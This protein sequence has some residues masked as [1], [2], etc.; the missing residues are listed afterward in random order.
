LDV[1]RNL[2]TRFKNNQ[3]LKARVVNS[4]ME[5]KMQSLLQKSVEITV[6]V[7]E[8]RLEDYQK[9][10]E[11]FGVL[12]LSISKPLKFEELGLA[13]IDDGQYQC[14]ACSKTFKGRCAKSNSAVHFKKFH[15]D[16]PVESSVQCPRCPEEMAKSSLN[17][18]MEQKHQL[19]NF[20]QL[21]KRSYLPDASEHSVDKG[22]MPKTTSVRTYKDPPSKMQWIQK[23]EMIRLGEE[24]SSQ[25]GNFLQLLNEHDSR[26]D[27]E[28][29]QQ[30]SQMNRQFGMATPLSLEPE[31][32][33]SN[34]D[35][36]DHI[37][38]EMNIKQE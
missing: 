32:S 19:K 11:D 3:E 22:K 38:E 17:S 30:C 4:K 7:D 21:L 33:K 13:A 36:I 10:A 1:L 15:T 25:E 18:H 12:E 28:A 20:N 9:Y 5:A 35:N 14:L 2:K 24:G 31:D 6:K 34:N 8:S 26:A 29:E 37:K 27:F 16:R 23:P